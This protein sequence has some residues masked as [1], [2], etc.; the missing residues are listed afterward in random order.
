MTELK[1]REEAGRIVIAPVPQKTYH[2][3]DLLRGITSKNLHSEID[4]STPEGEETW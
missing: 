4:F 1:L 3:D 2:L